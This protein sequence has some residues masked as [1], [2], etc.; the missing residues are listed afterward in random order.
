MKPVLPVA[1]AVM[2]PSLNPVVGVVDVA[3][4]ATVTPE[5]GLLADKVILVVPKQPAAL[6]AVS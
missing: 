4:T 6:L 5:Q 3:V 2:I 1:V